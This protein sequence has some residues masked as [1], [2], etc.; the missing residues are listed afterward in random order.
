MSSEVSRIRRLLEKFEQSQ[1]KIYLCD[2]S[3]FD[4]CEGCGCSWAQCKNAKA[5]GYW[6]CCPDCRH[7]PAGGGE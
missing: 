5:R 1:K 4:V 6:A 7:L 2:Q 3:A